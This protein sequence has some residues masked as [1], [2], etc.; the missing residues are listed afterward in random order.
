VKKLFPVLAIVILAGCLTNTPRIANAASGQPEVLLPSSVDPRRV[1][2]VLI[3]SLVSSG[4]QV[5]NDRE[6]GFTASR[7]MNSSEAIGR[8]A[9]DGGE[10][11]TFRDEITFTIVKVHNGLKVYAQPTWSKGVRGQRIRE[12]KDDNKTFNAWQQFLNGLQSPAPAAAPAPPSAPAPAAAPAPPSA[13]AQAEWK[14]ISKTDDGVHYI[15]PTTVLKD[16]QFR[17]VSQ[18]FDL[19]T[20][21]LFDGGRSRRFLIEYDCKE[22]RF[23]Y[24][25]GAFPDSVVTRLLRILPIMKSGCWTKTCTWYQ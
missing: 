12:P 4:Y 17:K 14:R 2:D 13:P 20:G 11:G 24:L 15:D 5:D 18:V 22:E 8:Q 1:H 7:Q 6:S 21:G 23:R 10:T 9:V 19:N 25:C 3:D 16:G